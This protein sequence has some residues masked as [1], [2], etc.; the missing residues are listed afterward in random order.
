MGAGAGTS[1]FA[2]ADFE[3]FS[4]IG[5]LLK[6]ADFKTP[7]ALFYRTDCTSR[8]KFLTHALV[9][10]KQSSQAYEVSTRHGQAALAH[11]QYIILHSPQA[12]LHNYKNISSHRQLGSCDSY[13]NK[14][15]LRTSE[16][17]RHRILRNTLI[18]HLNKRYIRK[19]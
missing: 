8:S 17:L 4:T 5:Y 16:S 19:S 10:N 7:R 12:L 18:N 3:V 13:L 14:R 1:P 2:P 11:T 9:S 6:P 15:Y